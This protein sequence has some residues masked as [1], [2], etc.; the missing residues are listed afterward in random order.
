MQLVSNHG[1]VSLV[2]LSKLLV[3]AIADPV[4]AWTCWLQWLDISP[5]SRFVARRIHFAS[6]D[7][8]KLMLLLAFVLHLGLLSVH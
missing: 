4:S 3:V 2:R 8:Q 1:N 6:Y 5:H 7:V